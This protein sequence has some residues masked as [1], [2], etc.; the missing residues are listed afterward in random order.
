MAVNCSTYSEISICKTYAAIQASANIF[1]AL[2][3]TL[4]NVIVILTYL[5]WRRKMFETPRDF[6]IF[7]LALADFLTAALVTPFGIAASINGSWSTGRAGCVWYGFITCWMGLTSILQLTGIA[8]ERYFTLAHADLRWAYICK[9]YTR[10]YIAFAWLASGLASFFPLLGWSRYDVE[11]IGLHCS[12]MWSET[13]LNYASY[14]SFLLVVFFT[15]PLSMI[16]Y[17]YAKVYLVVRRLSCE[18]KALWGNEDMATRQSYIAQ[19]KVARQ[20]FILTGMF[21]FAWTPY[22]LMSF[23][24]VTHVIEPNDKDSVLPAT[25]AKMSIVYNPLIYF[26]TFKRFR[27][28][29]I[30]LLK[31]QFGSST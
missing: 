21:L 22:A 10:S 25:F 12:I 17:F 11:G 31:L 15:V 27:K 23:L 14:S 8:A 2:F 29:S 18:A 30:Q 4:G 24:S 7:S 26:F 6:L 13:S 16:I 3:G 9:R 20:V 28:K 1:A 5:K 19:V